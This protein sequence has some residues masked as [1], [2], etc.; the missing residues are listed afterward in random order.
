MLTENQ[1]RWMFDKLL[2]LFRIPIEQVDEESERIRKLSRNDSM[3]TSMINV[4]MDEIRPGILTPVMKDYRN[5]VAS[6][7]DP[8]DNNEWWLA[9]YTDVNHFR[10]KYNYDPFVQELA[11]AFCREVRRQAKE[12]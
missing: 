6:H 5:L 11:D 2:Q 12:E 4:V 3:V 8:E 1:A 9:M 7:Q 10:K